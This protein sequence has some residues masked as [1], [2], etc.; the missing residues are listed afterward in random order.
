MS[1]LAKQLHNEIGRI[2]SKW[3]ETSARVK[4][5]DIRVCNSGEGD[6]AQ[7]QKAKKIGRNSKGRKV[8][9]AEKYKIYFTLQ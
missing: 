5:W 6:K 3:T 4:T 8:Q 2:Q 1:L 7:S 9:K